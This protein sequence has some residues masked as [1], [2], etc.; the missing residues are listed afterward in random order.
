[1]WVPAGFA[2]GYCTLEPDTEVVYKVTSPYDPECERGIQ[3]DDP[4]LAIDWPYSRHNG[5]LSDKDLRCRP[6][7]EHPVYFSIG[8]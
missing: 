7:R 3:F 8:G 6:L 2:H 5:R 1:M 4:D